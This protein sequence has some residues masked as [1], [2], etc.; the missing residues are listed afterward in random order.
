MKIT[1]PFSARPL[2]CRLSLLDKGRRI[3]IV[4]IVFGKFVLVLKTSRPANNELA[5]QKTAEIF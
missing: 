4:T 5:Q 2:I 1:F 3:R